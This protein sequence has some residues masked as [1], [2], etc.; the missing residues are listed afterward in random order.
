MNQLLKLT[1]I[2]MSTA[3][4]FSAVAGYVFKGI[5]LHTDILAV[6]TGVLLLAG[7]A[8]A[9]N[10]YQEREQDALMS[11]TKNRPI[12]SGDMKPSTALIYSLIMGVAGIVILYFLTTPLTA[13]LGL[14]NILWYNGVYTPLKRKTGFVVI[15]GA[16]TGAIPPMMGWTAAGG[17][18][19]DKG[20]LLMAAFF[21]LW[22]IPHFLLLLLK[23]KEDYKRAGFRAATNTLSDNQIKTITFAWILGTSL[24]TLFFPFFGIVSGP[25]LIAFMIILNILMVGFFYRSVFNRDLKFNIGSAFGS[26]YI[27]QLSVLAI[28]MVQALK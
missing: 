20:I 11:R 21:F 27:Y 2:N 24:I 13:V 7:S 6:F 5:G 15:V 23:Y 19:T 4:A 3:I 28:L 1:R 18:L 14:F 9:L 12:P 8:T 26:L 16:V 22:Q 17:S 10:Q 25:L